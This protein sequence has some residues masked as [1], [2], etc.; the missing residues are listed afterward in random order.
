[1]EIQTIFPGKNSDKHLTEGYENEA[2]I[3]NTSWERD[4][5]TLERTSCVFSKKGEKI[6]KSIT[7]NTVPSFQETVM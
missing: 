6:I 7:R 1:M 5:C 3:E 2:K 4:Y